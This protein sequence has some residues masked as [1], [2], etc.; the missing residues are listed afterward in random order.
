MTMKNYQCKKLSLNSLLQI[1]YLQ[2]HSL[3]E[4][5]IL[6]EKSL[7]KNHFTTQSPVTTILKERP[8]KNKVG[9]GKKNAGNQCFLPYPR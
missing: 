5:D 3:T 6:C 4:V 9:K 7:L 1:N 8:F 2:I